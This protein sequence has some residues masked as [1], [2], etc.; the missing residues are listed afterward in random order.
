MV[1]GY[2]DDIYA[3]SR[4]LAFDV[5]YGLVHW[6]SRK[7]TAYGGD[8]LDTRTDLGTL[9]LSNVPVVMVELGNMRNAHDAALMS[10]G[11]GQAR[12]A[13]GLVAGIRRY[14]KR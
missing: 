14:L 9:N 7:S 3:R 13:N 12:Y 1:K 10:S 2:T 6:K 11:T 4:T 8:G 5:R